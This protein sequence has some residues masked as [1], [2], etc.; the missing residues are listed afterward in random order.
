MACV[1]AD[2]EAV[3]SYERKQGSI[4]TTLLGLDR[5]PAT[6]MG[7]AINDVSRNS[8][9]AAHDAQSANNEANSAAS[10]FSHAISKI[11]QLSDSVEDLVRV[12]KELEDQA[13]AIASVGDVIRGIA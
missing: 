1:R 9:Q 2:A 4:D 12:I 5:F 13:V 6:E 11:T 7:A 8:Q 3:F 10:I